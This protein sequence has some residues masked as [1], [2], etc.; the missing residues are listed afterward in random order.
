MIGQRAVLW[1]SALAS[2]TAAAGPP[3]PTGARL[4]T[5]TPPGFYIGAAIA[6]SPLTD[7]NYTGVLQAEYNIGMAENATKM[8]SLEPS[9]GTF[10]FS[11]GDS[12]VSF[13]QAHGMKMQ[14]GPLVWADAVPAWVTGGGYT[15]AQLTSI[16]ETYITTVMQHYR[17]SFPGVV[18]SW[19]VVN[20]NTTTG[21]GVWAAIPNYV[22]LAFQTARQADPN[23]QLFYNDYGYEQGG[24]SADAVYNLVAPLKTQGLVD[25][26]GMQCHFASPVSESAMAANMSRFT[27][28]GLS[29][30]ITELDY[31]IASSD[32]VTANNPSDLLVQATAYHDV[33]TACVS[34]PGCTQ[35][36]TWGFT[37]ADSWIPS[38]FPGYGAALPFDAG[39][40][41]KPAYYAMQAVLAALP[42]PDAGPVA[43]P[44][45]GKAAPDAGTAVPDAGSGEA[46]ASSNSRD[47][48]GVIDG[49]GGGPLSGGCNC[50]SGNGAAALIVL[51]V[52][53]VASTIRR[54]KRP[55]ISGS[56][57][58]SSGW[59]PPMRVATSISARVP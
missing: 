13:A 49:G 44:D 11:Q 8:D 20:E 30:Y 35:F 9:S 27:A 36:L 41:A 21:P 18:I 43:G 17:D 14:A 16:M 15:A 6:V 57:G 28:L 34:T 50:E 24:S 29:V 7:P 4:R 45:A 52:I 47:G 48:G 42:R 54:R 38:F 46:D 12:V 32:G 39:Y 59:P 23:V 26:V 56:E 3:V 51:A 53:S 37:D 31:R 22:Q 55:S 33:L 40:E 1:I 2:T 19:E 10:D 25:G 5:L 58:D